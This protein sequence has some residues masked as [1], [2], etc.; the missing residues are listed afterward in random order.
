MKRLARVVIP[1]TALVLVLILS[2]ACNSLGR[3]SSGPGSPAASKPP[4][5]ASTPALNPAG[6]IVALSDADSA[7]T[8][9]VHKGQV[10]SVALH[11]ADGFTPWSRLTTSDSGVLIPIVDTR[12][13]AVRGMTLGSF[14]GA[15]PG[16][17][18]LASSATHDC[19]SVT[20]CR[21]V[22]RRWVVTVVVS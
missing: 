3:P 22:A 12:A 5:A 13:T 16:T 14:E 6:Q 10:V 4:P 19:V 17:A 8:L 18:E 1:G 11:E 15:A 7:R 20:P 9:F 2:Q 21:A